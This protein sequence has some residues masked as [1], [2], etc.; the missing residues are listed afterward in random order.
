MPHSDSGPNRTAAQAAVGTVTVAIGALSAAFATVAAVGRGGRGGRG[1]ARR[2]DAADAVHCQAGAVRSEGAHRHDRRYRASRRGSEAGA[3]ANTS[4]SASH[5]LS[6]GHSDHDPSTEVCRLHHSFCRCGRRLPQ[7]WFRL[8]RRKMRRWWAWCQR[9]Q[10]QRPRRA[11]RPRQRA[12]CRLCASLCVRV[13][14]RPLSIVPS[15]RRRFSRDR[16]YIGSLYHHPS[17]I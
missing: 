5:V 8:R 3:E 16:W 15:Y 4:D 17:I 12:S 14:V 11:D 13:I 7:G 2:D 6:Q 1:A 9:S 10:W